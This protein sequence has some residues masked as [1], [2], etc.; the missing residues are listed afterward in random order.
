M[1]FRIEKKGSFKILG[2]KSNG[3]WD[4]WQQFIQ[5]FD[6]DLKNGG[7]YKAPFWQVGAYK[8]L[9]AGSYYNGDEQNCPT[10]V[11]CI[12]GAEY[13][14]ESLL[15]GLEIEE[16]SESIWAIFSVEWDP[17]NDATGKTYARIISEWFPT[18]NY[19]RNESLPHL[20]VFGIDGKPKCEVWVPVLTK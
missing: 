5:R 3:G 1:D 2:K 4:D 15:E 20:E 13:N 11:N 17:D 8:F 16:F 12:I 19:K 7:Y 9:P 6:K 10:E 14:G 18:S